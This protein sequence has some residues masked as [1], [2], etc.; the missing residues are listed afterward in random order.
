MDIK[1]LQYLVTIA[2]EGSISRAAEKLFMAQSSLSQA[3]RVYE[4][5]LGTPI[6]RRTARGVRPTA[7]GAAFLV[8]A[9]QILQQYHLAQS[10]ILDIEELNGGT[11][12]FGISTFR[13][14]FLLPP[15]L[16]Q[17]HQ[18][19][20]KIHVDILEL[21]SNELESQILDGL[22]DIA[23]IAAPSPKIREHLDFLMH[24]EILI[25]TTRDHPV[26]EFAHS[27]E[28]APNRQ[29]IDLRDTIPFEYILGPP[30]TVLG[31]MARKEFRKYGLE[32]IVQNAHLS[33]GFAA[34]MAQ[35]GNGLA[36]TY[37]SCMVTSPDVR[38]LRIGQEGIFL[39]LALTYPLSGYRSRGT[40]ALGTLFHDMY[41]NGLGSV[42]YFQ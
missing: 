12:E 18:R 14:S 26:M 1:E 27:I 37:Q 9:R 2:N 20:P 11:I 7:A 16:K 19:Y 5:E 31:R 33:A 39:D 36:L 6:F 28:G 40:T 8:H 34:A 3:L 4:L 24:D 17:F 42:D 10:E 22:L 23:L 30:S 35:T 13:G 15:L 25:V 41:Q 29:W 21:D 32:P 38:Y